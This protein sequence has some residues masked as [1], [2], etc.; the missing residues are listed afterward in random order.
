MNEST[1]ICKRGERKRK[2]KINFDVFNSHKNLILYNM[3]VCSTV[4]TIEFHPNQQNVECTHVLIHMCKLFQSLLMSVNS[5]ST[6]HQRPYAILIYVKFCSMQ[7]T[8]IDHSFEYAADDYRV[9]L[10]VQAHFLT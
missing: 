7:N 5:F 10:P 8:F 2:R 9:F 6:H 4:K 1:H 3:G